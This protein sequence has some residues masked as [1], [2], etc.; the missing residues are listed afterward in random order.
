M[1]YV[2]DKTQVHHFTALFRI[3]ELLKIQN[4]T[5]LE[6]EWEKKLIHVTFGKVA[7]MSTRSGNFVLLSDVV[8][9]GASLMQ[10]NRA[11]SPNTRNADNFDIATKLA[12]S[13][14]VVNSLKT[15]RNR[16]INFDWNAALNPTGETGV[17]LQYTYARL[18]S[19]KAK[20]ASMFPESDAQTNSPNFSITYVMNDPIALNLAIH[21]VK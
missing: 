13:A 17:S 1:L 10:Q 19:L 16:D 14:L 12:I 20:L 11:K 4:D 18:S 6:D 21:L 2:V 9:F 3:M 15:R 7:G 5:S 8:E